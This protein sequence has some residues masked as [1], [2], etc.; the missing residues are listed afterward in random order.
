MPIFTTLS[1]A[2]AR[3]FGLRGGAVRKKVPPSS[4]EYLL[5]SAG[6]GPGYQGGSGAGGYLSQ[7][8]SQIAGD[9]KYTVTIPAGGG[10]KGGNTIWSGGDI[11]IFANGGGHGG[12]GVGGSGG[13]CHRDQDHG[14]GAGPAAGPG[15][16]HSGGAGHHGQWG[17]SGGGGG[18]G[19]AGGG[20][21]GGRE[22]WDGGGD[23]GAGLQNAI[24]G[25]Q[26]W[27]AGGGGGGGQPCN[28]PL[29]AG[30]QG[31]GGHGGNNCAQASAAQANTGGGGGGGG[32][33]AQS[34]N[35]GSGVL[36]LAHTNG[37]DEPTVGAGLT[38]TKDASSRSGHTFYKFTQGTDTISW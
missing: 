8:T 3:G 4:V 11:N 14:N 2:S 22:D 24:T 17:G 25:T 34:G 18:A 38:Y 12:T 28:Q 21:R 10:G 1:S 37:P 6:G 16:G 7:T 31:G 26:V 36:I 27:Y 32:G 23:G 9:I 30:G 5:V 15:L 13:G 29:A 35:G 33:N 20:S 19:A